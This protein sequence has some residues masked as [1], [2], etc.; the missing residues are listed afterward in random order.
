M[1]R[2]SALLNCQSDPRFWNSCDSSIK[3]LVKTSKISD[4][5]VASVIFPTN[6]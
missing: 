3:R 1:S 5:S 4:K 6:E 2:V